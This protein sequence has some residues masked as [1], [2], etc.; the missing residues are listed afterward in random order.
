MLG[1]PTY[2]FRNF[3]WDTD[4]TYARDKEGATYDAINGDYSAFADRGGKFI[5]YHGWA[6]SLITP[7]LTIHFW[8]RMRA[9]MGGQ[10][11]DEFARLFM[12]PGMD[13]CGGG[14]GGQLRADDVARAL[15]R[16]RRAAGQ[17]Q[18]GQHDDA[19]NFTCV[20]P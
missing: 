18:C 11:V 14:S 12:V 20:V 16:K 4:V 7:A 2:D 5:M 3:N 6:D 9:Q 13:H 10:K 19:A 15:G 17:H 1:N 8:N